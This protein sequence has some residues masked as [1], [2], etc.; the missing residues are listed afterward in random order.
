MVE[1]LARLNYQPL[2][3]T[4]IRSFSLMN[5]EFKMSFLEPILLAHMLV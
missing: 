5:V 2:C 4:N 3:L 1:A